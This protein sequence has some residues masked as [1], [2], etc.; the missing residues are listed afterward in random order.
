MCCKVFLSSAG[1]RKRNHFPKLY[2]KWVKIIKHLIRYWNKSGSYMGAALLALHPVYYSEYAE[3]ELMFFFENYELNTWEN[4]IYK[5][6]WV[7]SLSSPFFVSS[8]EWTNP[9]Y[10]RINSSSEIR[11]LGGGGLMLSWLLLKISWTSFL[12]ERVYWPL[13]INGCLF[14]RLLRCNG[15]TRSFW[16]V[17][18]AT[19]LYDT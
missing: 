10:V 11:H 5:L 7:R 12:R 6:K 1:L 13:L 3:W 14:I 17:C 2:V 8:V 9:Q 19:G 4:N 18:P 16:G 15:C